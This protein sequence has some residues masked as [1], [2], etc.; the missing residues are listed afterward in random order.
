VR[1]GAENGEVI[2]GDKRV[3]LQ[4]GTARLELAPGG[5]SVE[6]SVTGQPLQ[7]RNVLVTAGKE[8]VV[9]LALAASSNTSTEVKPEKPF[10][11]RKVIGG[12]VAVVGLVGLT[13]AAINLVA[14]FDDKDKGNAS[15]NGEGGHAVLPPQRT[16][17]DVCGQN[18]PGFSDSHPLCQADADAR[19]HSTIAI[20][21]GVGGALLVGAGA[22]LFLTAP[23]GDKPTSGKR[24][25]VT[26]MF[27]STTGGLMLSGSF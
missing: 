24:P 22:F 10:P 25:K 6:V 23:E 3:P 7:K 11:T 12:A 9:D 5:H 26:P 19:T 4:S 13:L 15:K 14:Y 8:T 17:G 18:L 2:D 21:T 27:G 20:V 16:P 1:F